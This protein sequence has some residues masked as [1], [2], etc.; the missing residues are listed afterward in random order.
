MR[1]EANRTAIANGRLIFNEI[2]I[3]NQQGG[4]AGADNGPT[5][6]ATIVFKSCGIDRQR[7]ILVDNGA[8]VAGIGITEEVAGVDRDHTTIVDN[9]R[10]WAATHGEVVHREGYIRRDQKSAALEGDFAAAINSRCRGDR[11]V[12]GQGDGGVIATIEGDHAAAGQG[13]CQRGLGTTGWVAV[14]DNP[15]RQGQ[16]GAG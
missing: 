3:V 11:L 13:G 15:G 12:G 6:G 10:A 8:T 4:I 14:A 1:G 7:A 9:G 2:T 16:G 5:V